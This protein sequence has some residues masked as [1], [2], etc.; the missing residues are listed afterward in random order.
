MVQLSLVRTAIHMYLHGDP[1]QIKDF[2]NR[3]TVRV[4]SLGITKDLGN[5][6]YTC[7]FNSLF[8]IARGMQLDVFQDFQRLSICWP[9]LSRKWDPTGNSIERKGD[10]IEVIISSCLDH[11]QYKGD[12]AR[13]QRRFLELCGG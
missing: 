4:P 2:S 6:M 7:L 3:A 1:K 9:T 8:E 13:N 10:V 11:Q 5:W 12:E